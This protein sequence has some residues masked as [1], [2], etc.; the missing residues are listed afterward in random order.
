MNQWI[1]NIIYNCVAWCAVPHR[2]KQNQ[3][4]IVLTYV[5]SYIMPLNVSLRIW[6]PSVLQ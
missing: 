6:S 5:E 3:C 1:N 2:G 4:E